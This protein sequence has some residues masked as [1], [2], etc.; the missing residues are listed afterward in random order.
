MKGTQTKALTAIVWMRDQ[1]D[2][3]GWLL[4]SRGECDISY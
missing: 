3:L 1:E 4:Y 2:E